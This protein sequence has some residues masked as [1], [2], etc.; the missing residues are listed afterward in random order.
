MDNELT[1]EECGKSIELY[2]NQLE[3]RKYFIKVVKHNKKELENANYIFETDIKLLKFMQKRGFKLDIDFDK[4]NNEV[5]ELISKNK[6]I[7]DTEINIDIE[8]RISEIK[9]IKTKIMELSQV[10]G[11]LM[12][13]KALSR[14]K[15]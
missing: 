1:I 5:Q 12:G 7:I 4:Y 2:E 9:D 11:F 13:T 15:E 10:S 6:N 3:Y 8:K 14:K